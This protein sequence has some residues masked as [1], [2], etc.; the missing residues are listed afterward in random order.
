MKLYWSVGAGGGRRGRA[1]LLGVLLGALGLGL[2]VGARFHLGAGLGQGGLAGLAAGELV[3]DGQ[4]VLERRGVGGFGL[5]QELLDLQLDLVELFAG[6]FVADCA[7]SAG[8]GE[9]L[10]AVDGHRDV[11]YLKLLAARGQLEDLREGIGQQRAVLPAELAD[12]VVVGVGVGA[13]VAHRHVVEGALLDAAAGKR[14][15]RVAV[16]QQ[17]QHRRGWV[18]LAAAAPL[19]DPGVA[20]VERLDRIDD[21]VHEVILRYPVLQARGQ[22]HRGVS[23]HGHEAGGHALFDAPIVPVF[24]LHPHFFQRAQPV[25]LAA[26]RRSPTGC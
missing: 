24:I 2:G 20:Q 18:L 21:E 6:A 23:V 12:G 11:A 22:Q 10:R 9:D 13:E 7:V 17:R 1:F 4:A 3:V 25:G 5:G 26:C 15:G 19:V 14:A 16:H 8:V